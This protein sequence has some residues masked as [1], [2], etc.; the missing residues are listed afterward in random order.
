MSQPHSSFPSSAAAVTS[1]SAPGG[2]V[3]HHRLAFATL[4]PRVPHKVNSKYIGPICDAN[5]AKPLF[6]FAPA[7]GNNVDKFRPRQTKHSR[8][9][10]N[11]FVGYSSLSSD[12]ADVPS[13]ADDNDSEDS[14]DNDTPDEEESAA[15]D[16]GYSSEAVETLDEAAL[17]GGR[18]DDDDRI[19]EDSGDD[20]M[21]EEGM[22]DDD[23]YD[24]EDDDF[25]FD[26]SA[27]TELDLFDD[28]QEAILEELELAEDLGMLDDDE[29]LIKIDDDL[30]IK[31]RRSGIATNSADDF[32]SED[33]GDDIA[34]GGDDDI[35]IMEELELAGAFDEDGKDYRAIDD[36]TLLEILGLPDE[37]VAGLDE[38]L[39]LEGEEEIIFQAT[40]K[41]LKKAE[42]YFNNVFEEQSRAKSTEIQAE[43][44]AKDKEDETVPQFSFQP[45]ESA[46]E[47]GVVPTEAGVGSGALPGDFGFDPFGFSEKDWFKQT[48]RAMLSVV[49]EKKY[50]KEKE[51]SLADEENSGYD[52][53][54]IPRNMRVKTF[55]DMEKRPA[56][57]IIR[58]YRE[59]E[60]RHG[61]L[62]STIRSI[63][64]EWQWVLATRVLSTI[65]KILTS[66]RPTFP[67]R[68]FELNP[69]PFLRTQGHARC[70]FLAF[71][72]AC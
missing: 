8:C 52:G 4:P 15:G 70:D 48:Q 42:Q 41:D 11:I 2:L 58:D 45:L 7:T 20:Y 66:I 3:P 68:F 25:E 53:G 32:G 38:A 12:D 67:L 28:E 18:D 23:I 50:D 17:A 14:D 24:D 27:L 10:R 30:V 16:T 71:A 26:E 62:V 40:D 54:A 49:P 34:M 44:P 69:S 43:E 1:A 13:I 21:G 22:L 46:L 72:G 6:D 60:I 47:L 39:A 59:A 31:A 51:G 37:E 33:K 56:S 36:D 57:L 65:C 63:C 61:R 55:D 5:I 9:R 19:Y 29:F 64:I 35:F